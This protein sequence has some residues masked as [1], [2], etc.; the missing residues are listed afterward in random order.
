MW[1][2]PYPLVP[3]SQRTALLISWLWLANQCSASC[4]QFW[5]RYS[6]YP[7]PP[8]SCSLRSTPDCVLGFHGDPERTSCHQAAYTDYGYSTR[9]NTGLRCSDQACQSPLIVSLFSDL[10]PLWLWPA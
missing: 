2:P 3:E 6:A 5:V 8:A 10:W 1:G 4:P 7:L 9:R